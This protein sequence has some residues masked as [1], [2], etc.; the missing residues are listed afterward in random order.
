MKIIVMGGA[1]LIGSKLVKKLREQGHETVTASPNT[2]VNS[3]SGR[4]LQTR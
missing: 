4:D 3:I 2:G 1:G